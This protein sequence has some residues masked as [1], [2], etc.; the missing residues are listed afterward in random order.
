ML[1]KIQLYE[2]S[3]KH[4]KQNQKHVKDCLTSIPSLKFIPKTLPSL[5]GC[6]NPP[7]RHFRANFEFRKEPK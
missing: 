7:R 5:Q 3:Q 6:Q 4:S 1:Q 2:H